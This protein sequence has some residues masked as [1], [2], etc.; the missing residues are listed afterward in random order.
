MRGLQ[1]TDCE[2]YWSLQATAHLPGVPQQ[3]VLTITLVTPSIL[4]T[5]ATRADRIKRPTMETRTITQTEQQAC[6][7]TEN[8][9]LTMLWWFSAGTP[10][11]WNIDPEACE[12]WEMTFLVF[13]SRILGIHEIVDDKK[14]TS[15][16]IHWKMMPLLLYI[17]T[18]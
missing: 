8:L 11:L 10:S 14:R 6:T 16:K 7:T 17:H 1:N 18:N 5:M 13:V 2:A 12:G 3:A 4:A 15:V 9:T